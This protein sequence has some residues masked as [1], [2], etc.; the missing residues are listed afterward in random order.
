MTPE[1]TNEKLLFQILVALE[2]PGARQL[3]PVRDAYR[4]WELKYNILD[5]A[6][7]EDNCSTNRGDSSLPNV[8]KFVKGLSAEEKNALRE[9]ILN[10]R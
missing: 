1:Q 3:Q 4:L 2:V 10:A 5:D 7:I 9:R 8:L 6:A